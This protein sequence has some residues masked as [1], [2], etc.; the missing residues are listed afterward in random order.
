[1]KKIFLI[2]TVINLV[3]NIKILYAQTMNNNWE[4]YEEA[5]RYENEGNFEK[6]L[7]LYQKFYES[8]EG[9]A[10]KITALKAIAQ[11][12]KKIK[13]YDEAIE[14][15]KKCLE[16]TLP[17][18]HILIIKT[19]MAGCYINQGKPLLG[20][21]IYDEII[22]E[23]SKTEYKTEIAGEAQFYKANAYHRL[24][25]DYE[26]AISE[27]EKMIKEYPEHWSVKTPY[28]LQ[29]IAS[30]YYESKKYDDTIKVFEKIIKNY[31][32]TPFEKYAKLCI[33]IINEYDKKGK[34]VPPEII[35]K[36][37]KEMGLGEGILNVEIKDGK[38]ATEI[39]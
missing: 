14:I 37:M 7:G 29:S 28:S 15:Y 25:K 32:N 1:M 38:V 27:Y 31:P 16:F 2:F 34:T 9:S 3:V 24:I 11:L 8:S 5:M 20:I 17:P 12:Y 18:Q 6:A 26:K 19:N 4:I 39:K 22:E 23:Y 21:K 10:A 33:E 13:K 35:M 30:C 36:K